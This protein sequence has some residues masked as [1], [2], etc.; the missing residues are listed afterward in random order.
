MAVPQKAT[1]CVRFEQLFYRD[2]LSN[3]DIEFILEHLDSCSLGIHTHSAI[4]GTIDSL[5]EVIQPDDTP[6]L[7]KDRH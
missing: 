3:D 4:R 1:S 6:T 2:E 7:P 5:S